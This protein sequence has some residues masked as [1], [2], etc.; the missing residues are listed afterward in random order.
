MVYRFAESA[1][2]MKAGATAKVEAL[3]ARMAVPRRL[4]D[5]NAAG[6]VSGVTSTSAGMG[7]GVSDSDGTAAALHGCGEGVTSGGPVVAGGSAAAIGGGNFFM[8]EAHSEDLEGVKRVAREDAEAAAAAWAAASA[9]MATADD[10][11]AAGATA[12][13]AFEAPADASTGVP[14]DRAAWLVGG[15]PISSMT[16]PSTTGGAA[17]EIGGDNPGNGRFNMPPHDTQPVME[18]REYSRSDSSGEE[19]TARAGARRRFGPKR[20]RAYKPTALECVRRPADPFPSEK[21]KNL[22]KDLLK[23]TDRLKNLRGVLV[24]GNAAF[25]CGRSSRHVRLCTSWWPM[26]P[27]QG[28]LW[29]LGVM[30]DNALTRMAD[31]HK[32]KSLDVNEK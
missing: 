8:A 5:A 29:S 14:P 2:A 16:A 4:R 7:R 21:A 31:P 22:A 28:E 9:V 30:V 11:E 23:P 24:I 17:G 18:D 19:P 27:N 6:K 1:D 25:S 20:T 3:W 26:R 15:P 12:G 32:S 10:D 13:I